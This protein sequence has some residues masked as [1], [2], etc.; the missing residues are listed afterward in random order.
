MDAAVI[1]SLVINYKKIG[2]L[3]YICIIVNFCTGLLEDKKV[4][5]LCLSQY[6]FFWKIHAYQSHNMS[7]SP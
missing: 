7:D 2:F 1:I 4:V 3:V 5:T 6:D